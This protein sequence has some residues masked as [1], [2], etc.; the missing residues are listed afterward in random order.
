MLRKHARR[1]GFAMV[2]S[3][4]VAASAIAAVVP[5]ESKRLGRAKEFIAEEQWSRAIEELQAAVADPKETGRAEALYWLAHSQHQT[6]DSNSA[7]QTIKRLE[8]EFPSSAW[9][10][11]AGSLRIDIAVRLRRNDVLWW[12]AVAPAV[13]PAAAAP[14]PVPPRPPRP[15]RLPPAHVSEPLPPAPPDAPS[16]VVP[17]PRPPTVWVPEGFNPDLDLR[18]QALGHLIRS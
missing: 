11:A 8:R 15:P 9:V 7:L 6:G 16:A 4:A 5:G 17:V 3:L 14:T 10:Q 2:I 12:T 18:I 13:P 1:I